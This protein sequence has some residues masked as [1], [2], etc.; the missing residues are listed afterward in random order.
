MIDSATASRLELV[1]SLNASG[2]PSLMKALN[3]CQTAA[4]A[5]LLRSNLLEPLTDV[6]VINQRLDAV[7][8]MTQHPAQ[9]FQPVKVLVN[10]LDWSHCY[11]LIVQFG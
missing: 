8:E 9:L 2:G 3:Y 5:R 1:C 4:G 6:G 11:L 10:S 7:Q